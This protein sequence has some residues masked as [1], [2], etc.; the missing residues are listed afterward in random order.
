MTQQ[1]TDEN[2]VFLQAKKDDQD[3]IQLLA[4][5]RSALT[6]FYTNHSIELGPLQNFFLVQ[7]GP[8]FTV[9]EDQ[10]PEATFSGKGHRKVESKGIVQLLTMIMQDLNDEIKNDMKA[11]ELAQLEYEK[12]L[13]AANALKGELES[14]KV[15][16]SDMIS[17][18]TVDKGD[19]EAALTANQKDLQDEEDYRKQI[20]PDCDWIIGAFTERASR[21]AAEMQGLVEAKD[22]L[23]G[24]TP[25]SLLDKRHGTSGSVRADVHAH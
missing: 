4:S 16:L 10:A 13:A 1:R 18:R 7:Q 9:S 19:E 24:Y 22:F 15:N 3:A 6:A 25:S 23:A 12:Q 8:N 21:R 20:T 2:A 5:A 14:K 17:K 11:E